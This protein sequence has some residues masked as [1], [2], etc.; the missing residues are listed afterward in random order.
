MKQ[1]VRSLRILRR[2]YTWCN[3]REKEKRE[4]KI[5]DVLFTRSSST[6]F[7]ADENKMTNTIALIFTG[8]TKIPRTETIY[9]RESIPMNHSSRFYGL[10]SS[11]PVM[12]QPITTTPHPC[13]LDWLTG[14]YAN[15]PSFD[16]ARN[17]LE[18]LIDLLM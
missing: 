12:K 7:L 2:N 14:I 5:Y 16:Y 3:K 1:F 11:T 15:N 8:N 13:V 10:E 17:A 4:R 18:T 9:K 6:D